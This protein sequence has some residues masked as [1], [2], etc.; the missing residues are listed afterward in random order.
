MTR[1]TMLMVLL[2]IAFLTPVFA[3]QGAQVE[4][5]KFE[6]N[7]QETS[8]AKDVPAVREDSLPHSEASI[9]LL[10]R[11]V[12]WQRYLREEMAKPIASLK[13]GESGAWTLFLL[14]C[15]TYGML[16]A[17]GPGHGKSVVAAYFVSRKANFRQGVVLG[18]AVTLVHAGSAVLLLY[19]LFY[20]AGNSAFL[21]FEHNRRAM[22]T[23]GYSLLA[24]TGVAMVATVLVEWLGKRGHNHSVAK[25][26]STPEMLWLAFVTGFV[27]CPAVALVTLF[28]LLQGMPL[29]GLAGALFIATGMAITNVLS[30][31][32]SIALR[33]GLGSAGNRISF[34]ALL[35]NVLALFGGLAVF[36]LGSWMIWNAWNVPM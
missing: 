20:L 11:L 3:Q 8:S 27:P 2:A 24:L 23:I 18:L 5:K 14:L 30:A 6:W 17:L 25:L 21:D 9:S 16:H 7:A 26:A 15:A 35:H 13:A 36:G 1:S 10:Q 19:S 22:E 12:H 28:C 4:R 33:K 34:T 29:A 31:M 32:V